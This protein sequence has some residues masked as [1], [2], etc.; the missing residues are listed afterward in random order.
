MS[1]RK[2]ASLFA[3]AIDAIA[4]RYRLTILKLQTYR[5]ASH[6]DTTL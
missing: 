1:D 6:T 2:S 3:I 4:G 5:F